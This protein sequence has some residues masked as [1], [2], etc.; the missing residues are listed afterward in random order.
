MS[1][2]AHSNQPLV[3]TDFG[4]VVTQPLAED[5]SRITA[6]TAT[7][8][9]TIMN[10][11]RNVIAAV[12]ASGSEAAKATLSAASKT[13]TDQLTA[14][15]IQMKLEMD[16]QAQ[17]EALR[18]KDLTKLISDESDASVK[19]IESFL[20][21]EDIKHLNISEVIDYTKK[22][23][24]AKAAVVEPSALAPS[25]NRGDTACEAK[26]EEMKNVG[27]ERKFTPSSHLLTYA[28]MC[29]VGKKRQTKKA[30]ETAAQNRTHI[31]SAKKSQETLNKTN[32]KEAQ[33]VRLKEQISSNCTPDAVEKGLCGT[34]TKGDYI[35]KVLKNEIIPNGGVSASN[36]YAPAPVGGAG[37]LNLEDPQLQKMA[38][39]VEFDSLEKTA[40]GKKDLPPI[41]QTY[42]N[43]AQLKAAEAFVENI[44]NLDAIGNQPVSERKKETSV[45]FQSKFM[46]RAAQLDL[47]K[48]TLN[49]S[50]AERRGQKLSGIPMSSIQQ[51]EMIKEVEDGAGPL[52]LK[53][54]QI[55][56]DMNKV[57][58]ANID[59]LTAMSDNQIWLEM[60]TTLVKK[61]EAQFERMIR[62]ERQSLLL[63]AL[64][65]AEANDPEN[66]EYLKRV[67]E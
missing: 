41:V 20:R 56:E 19:F 63:A 31:D 37:I 8:S 27:F 39:I 16:Y 36:L 47:A 50:V 33:S 9:T 61:N 44:V 1:Y 66:I 38:K 14:A 46:S 67:G 54:H 10:A 29:A 24:D 18:Q 52:D 13:S 45:A 30:A 26:K 3:V 22:E 7:T 51:G 2:G 49:Q 17:L 34:V 58:P 28:E 65:A 59:Q 43:S 35:E 62:L 4:P 60:Y 48:S 11:T 23:V 5:V 40:G 21:R 25:C 64:L 32:S 15:Q 53:W 55:Q 6:A 42:R 12:H 57:S